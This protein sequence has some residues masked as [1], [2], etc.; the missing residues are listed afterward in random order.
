FFQ[1]TTSRQSSKTGSK[2]SRRCFPKKTSLMPKAT[3]T[4]LEIDLNALDNNYRHITSKIKPGTKVLAVVKAFGYGSDSVV[5]AK[6]LAVLGADY[7]A[8]AYSNE[9]ETL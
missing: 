8:V 7:F 3:E 5:I 2:G 1:G 9:G 4:V 6:E